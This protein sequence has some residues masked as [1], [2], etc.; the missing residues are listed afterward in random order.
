MKSSLVR[1]QRRNGL[2]L[3]RHRPSMYSVLL[4]TKFSFKR[5]EYPDQGNTPQPLTTQILP[6]TNSNTLTAETGEKSPQSNQ[7]V[8]G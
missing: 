3:V 2:I 6:I 7:E 4:N 8:D 5:I 1:W